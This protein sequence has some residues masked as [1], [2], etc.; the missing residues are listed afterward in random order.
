M[1]IEFCKRGYN[2]LTRFGKRWEEKMWSY[3]RRRAEESRD[4]RYREEAGRE[5][6]TQGESWG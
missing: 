4:K 5:V 6:P 1:F 2:Q 3:E